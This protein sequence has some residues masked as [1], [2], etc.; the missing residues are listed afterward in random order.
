MTSTLTQSST[1]PKPKLYL[2]D[3]SG[4]IFRAFHAIPPLT[5][6]DGTQ[7]NAVYGFCTMLSKLLTDHHADYITVVFDAS[8][9][10]F[11]NSIYPEYKAHRPP[12]PPELIPQFPLIR[13]ATTAFNI[14]W[15]QLEGY[16]AD[17][18]IATFTEIGK[19]NAFETI[20]V[21]SDKDLMQLVSDDVTMFDHFK[22]IYITPN[23][24][25]EK[26]GVP[27]S[28]MI[29]IQ[30]LMGDSSDNVPGVP[31]I[32]PKTA[33]ELI[34]QFDTLE[35]LLNNLDQ[36][37]QKGRRENLEIYQEQARISHQLVTLRKDV[38][39]NISIDDFKRKDLHLPDLLQFVKDLNF[40]TLL[41]RFEKLE[42]NNST[43]TQ[44]AP[45]KE[46]YACVTDIETLQ[47]WIDACYEKGIVAV[48][49]ETTALNPQLAQ[50]AGVSLAISKGEACYI[51]LS[52]VGTFGQIIKEQLNKDTALKLL[53]PMLEDPSV[54]KIGHNIKYDAHI[55]AHYGIEISP[56][57]DTM[58]L[59]YVLENGLHGHSLDE[60]ASLFFNHD[61]IKFKDVVGTGKSQLIF[62]QIPLNEA[63]E[64]A[65][66][67]ADYT[68]R[69]HEILKPR[70]IEDHLV[71]LYEEIE[72]PLIPVLK[73][74]EKKGISLDLN[75]LVQAGH[76]FALRAKD[77]EEKIFAL[78][79]QEFN[80]GSPKQL[81]E[82]LFDKLNLPAPKKGK[83]GNYETNSDVLEPLAQEGHVITQHVLAWRQY[84]KLISTYV[85]GLKQEINPKTNRVHTSYGMTIASTGRLNS[86]NP[87]LQNIPTR[88]EEGRQIRRAFKAAPGHKLVSF[89]YS[90]I[91]LRLLAELAYIKELR[92]AFKN[93]EDIH[94]LT[95]SQIFHIPLDEVT[96]DVRRKAKAINFGIIYGISAFGL[97]KQLGCPNKEA[98]SYI[99][100]YFERYPGIQAYMEQTKEFC[101]QHGFVK[102]LMGR[103]CFIPDINAKNGAIRSFSERAAINAPLQGSNADIIKLA[104]VKIHHFLLEKYPDTSMLLQVHD[105]LI[106]EIPDKDVETLK[107]IIRNM[108]ENIVPLS[109]PLIVDI[110]VGN[111]WTEAGEK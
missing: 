56:F 30:S 7:V 38:P 60:L 101:R 98:D 109:V 76:T 44:T 97:A 41:A 107:P 15:F 82:I 92:D 18:L 51:P 36:I 67:D 74:M 27:P 83:A 55:F 2:I 1:N 58:L 65:A 31:K 3:G 45:V 66:E 103:K 93:K 21:S 94:K 53:K 12:T 4:F 64:Y 75:A 8:R 63:T 6:K 50:I 9:E 61:M 95:A 20:I 88:T 14:P 104:M 47:K 62:T 100:S 42:P 84:S 17:D 71:A 59:S 49:T 39:I 57:D 43:S 80:I 29:E 77:L 106:F 105:E 32:G 90:Q 91:E 35:N 79:G 69:L 23:E 22:N 86:S 108:M 34:Q 19:A 40:K 16:E 73:A 81:G 28:K 110:G 54:L 33:A 99:K 102:T 37:P 72:R 48:D 78:A 68:F 25:Q 10:N 70:L 13:E 11:R 24:V 87:N 111:N 46:T 89:D 52:H 26:Y 96:S 5:R 85:E